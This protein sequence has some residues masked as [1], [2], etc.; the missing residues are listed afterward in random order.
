MDK[1]FLPLTL[2]AVAL[3]ASACVLAENTNARELEPWQQAKATEVW[4]PVPEAISAPENA[5]PSDAINLLAE[6][7]LAQW[8]SVKGGQ[9]KWPLNHG[10]LTVAPGAG[11]IKTR[12][13]FCDV[14]LHLEWRTPADIHGE[15]GE[16]LVGQGRGNSGVFLQE[17]Y[18]I[19]L[20]DSFANPTYPNGQ[21]ASIYKQTI[22]LVN[23][24]RGPG[25]WQS[26]DIIFTAPRFNA[27][28]QLVAPA[29]ITLLHNGVLVQNH[30][31]VQ[32][33]TAWIGHPPYEAH[34]CA[35]LQLQDH[36]NPVSFRNIWLRK[37]SAN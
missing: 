27:E 9:L 13:I 18:E 37:L 30:V 5:A 4:E 34:G 24:S 26:Y 7:N 16:P 35:A 8:Q 2:S 10:V 17:R 19:Q 29:R 6:N 21:A 28:Q 12:D 33:P 25:Q 32:G 20:L 1:H 23:A 11:D 3:W 36:G 14:Q 15:D 22:P 31:A